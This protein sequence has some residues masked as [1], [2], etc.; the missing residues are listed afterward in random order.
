MASL[1]AFL[2]S[3]TLVLLLISPA[4]THGDD[5]ECNHD[6][7]EQNPE[8]L[9]V[10]EDTYNFEDEGRVLASAPTS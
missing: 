1:K 7:I 4:L 8:L 5:H 6:D 10:E 2:L 9:D 3:L